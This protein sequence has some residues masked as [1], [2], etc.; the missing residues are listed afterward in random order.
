MTGSTRNDSR[1][2]SPPIDL[3]LE[4]VFDFH[5]KENPNHS[6]FTY[7]TK[8]DKRL[9]TCTYKEF[10]PAVHR[11][12]QAISNSIGLQRS[13]S[14]AVFPV[15][16]V[17]LKTDTVTYMTVLA[18]LLRAGYTAFPISPRFSPIVVAHLLKESRPVAIV[19]DTTTKD[20]ANQ[21]LT[22]STDGY[23][24]LL[25]ELPPFSVLYS[26]DDTYI[27][28]PRHDR[29]PE[30]ISIITH[31]SSSSAIFPKVI[32]WSSSAV[33]HHGEIKGM[34]ALQ[35]A[36]SGANEEPDMPVHQLAGQILGCFALELFHSFGMAMFFMTIR[37]GCVMGVMDPAEPTSI[38]PADMNDVFQCFE[39]TQPDFLMSNA[40]AVELW[41]ED[42]KKVLAL[43]NSPTKIFYGGRF[44][45][46]GVGN[47]L[48]RYGVKLCSS[49]GGTECGPITILP[50]FQGED[51]EYWTVYPRPDIN[52]ISR[53]DGLAEL[54]VVPTDEPNYLGATNTTWK[55]KPAYNPGDLFFPHPTKP[56]T[57]K[58]FGRSADQI[59]LATGESINPVEIAV[60]SELI[61]HSLISNAIMFGHS[62]FKVGVVI[63]PVWMQGS[64]QAN[65][66]S[67]KIFI[68]EIWPAIQEINLTSPS[69]ANISRNMIIVAD[70]KKPISI[71]AKGLPRR[72]VVWLHYQ[73][74]IDALYV[75]DLRVPR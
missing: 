72:P 8:D 45:N 43:S 12:G 31:S 14:T 35:H 65:N 36:V 44:L 57:Y 30:D 1:F 70:S 9:R 7:P 40:R 27:S 47:S 66:M 3:P 53:G 42:P 60:E 33:T 69:Y 52:F 74:E 64:V 17:I 10:I 39:R 6:A 37:R 34:V 26:K 19:V 51:W 24:P 50:H 68:D 59:L 49:Y 16:V 62:R 63:E 11:A 13:K 58:M 20:L 38:L 55:G 2:I 54:I 5:Y 21:A 41:A 73:D 32:S 75:A 25:C 4:F 46:K 67:E 29:K 61:R 23:K 71:S 48:V 28:L 18:G 22:G 56:H 15:V